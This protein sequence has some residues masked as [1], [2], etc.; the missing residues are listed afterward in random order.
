VSKIRRAQRAGFLTLGRPPSL[1][2]HEA[3]EELLESDAGVQQLLV[4]AGVLPFVSLVWRPL[5][6]MLRG[7]RD[8]QMLWTGAHSN[9]WSAWTKSDSGTNDL[10]ESGRLLLLGGQDGGGALLGSVEALQ[11]S[12]V[13]GW[14]ARWGPYPP[15]NSP[16]RE[17]GVV[18]VRL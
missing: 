4:R 9:P 15:L 6:N 11:P 14:R 3:E 1:S 12:S 7:R 17:F 18:A 13:H 8:C 5:P 16:R 10:T 2:C